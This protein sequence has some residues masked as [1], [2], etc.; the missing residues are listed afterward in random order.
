MID[1]LIKK[2]KGKKILICANGQTT[3]SENQGYYNY[4]KA[5]EYVWTVNGGWNLHPYSELGFMMD[6]WASIAHDTDSR[7]REE[8]AEALRQCKIPV[9][10]TTRYAEFDCLIEYPL[11]KVIKK[12]KQGYFGETTS[13]MIAF[14]IF[15]EASEIHM[16]G[17]DYSGCKA[18]ERAS[19]EF[20]CGYAAAKG[21]KVVTNTKSHFMCTQL[22]DRNNHVPNFYGYIEPTFPFEINTNK[23]ETFTI[24]F[25]SNRNKD[26]RWFKTIYKDFIKA[27]QFK[28]Q[29]ERDQYKKDCEKFNEKIK[30]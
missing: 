14:A 20:W 13:Y 11:E 8:K 3:I 9:L 6:D 10:T 12:L 26:I 5:Y 17:T 19:T 16:T 29:G 4:S 27:N 25:K 24:D 18:A 21:I 15:C 1:K 28:I 7:T 2:Y 22:D 30:K 23:D